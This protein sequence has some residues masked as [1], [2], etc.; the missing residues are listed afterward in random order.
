[1]QLLTSTVGRVLY[2]LPFG[3]FGLMYFMAATEMAGSFG[4]I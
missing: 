1:M 2:A 3:I 4:F